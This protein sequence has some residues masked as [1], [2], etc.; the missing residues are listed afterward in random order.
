MTGPLPVVTGNGGCSQED[1]L[2]AATVLWGEA[3]RYAVS[4]YRRINA[5]L[6]SG[7]L[8][9]LPVVIGLTA[10]GKCLGATRGHGEWEAGHLPRITLAPEI[11]NGSRRMT[12]GRN[13]VTDVI[14]HEMVHARLILDGAD[15]SH[16]ARPWCE[17]VTRLSPQ[18]LGHEVKAA[19]VNPR[20]VDGKVI[21]RPREGHLQRSILAGW[22]GSLRP[23]GWDCGESIPVET[24]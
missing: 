19:P 21:R 2:R 4:E 6:F 12:G 15:P 1:Y 20:R 24:Y 10:Y 18:V 17:A 16:N 5:W 3:G 11:F 9:P 22:P 7:A 14:T 8:P 23:V 13:V